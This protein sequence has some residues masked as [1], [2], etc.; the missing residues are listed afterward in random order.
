VFTTELIE[1]FINELL[2]SDENTFP[3]NV[4]SLYVR[5]GVEEFNEGTTISPEQACYL[6]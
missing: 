6:L 1:Q 4:C 3:E 2:G 5:Q